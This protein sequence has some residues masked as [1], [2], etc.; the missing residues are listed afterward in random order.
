MFRFDYSKDFLLWA[1]KPPG[2]RGEWHAGV[3]VKT[4]K[5]MV[6]FISAIPAL[7]SV[8]GKQLK[9]V[10][11]NFLCVHKKLRDKRLAPL[12][13]KE[14]TRRV[15]LTGIFQ[16][17]YTAGTVLPTPVAKCRYWHRNLNPKKLVNVG[18]SHL[19]RRMTLPRAVKLY[20]LPAAPLTPGI[21]PMEQKDV[22]QV[23]ALIKAYLV[24]FG[25]A[26]VF[27]KAEVAHWFLPRTD[28][29]VSYVVEDKATGKITDF[30]SFYSLPSTIIGNPTYKTLRAAYSY[31]NVAGKTPL[32]NL[33][34]DALILAS[35]LG[36]DVYNCLDLMDNESILQDLKFGPG[37]GNLHYYLYNWKANTMPAKDVA[38]VLM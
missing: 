1:L 18:F 31:Y 6:A 11:I 23:A 38:L 4:S 12:L 37:D 8:R 33:M 34:Q 16:A 20:K 5:K 21:R 27:S 32:K 26:P 14:I 13:I 10:E 7:I 25:L 35:S 36:Y 2:W 17:V 15:N 22:K 3:R 29:I 28:V 30:L 9:M 24:R 19:T